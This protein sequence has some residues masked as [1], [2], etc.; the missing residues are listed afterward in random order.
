MEVY[1][2]I[3]P[4]ATSTLGQAPWD[5][6][7]HIQGNSALT[8]RSKLGRCGRPALNSVSRPLASLWD[9]CIGVRTFSNL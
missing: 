5:D 4:L 2:C 1:I 6:T 9:G 3:T 7:T 8:A